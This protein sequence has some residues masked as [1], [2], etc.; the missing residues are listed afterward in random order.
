M[1]Y[2]SVHR[3]LNVG[4]TA[5]QARLA[6]KSVHR[7]SGDW[8]FKGL[9]GADGGALKVVELDDARHGRRDIRSPARRCDLPQGLT[10][11]D[12]GGHGGGRPHRRLS[13]RGRGGRGGQ[14]GKTAECES[15]AG[16][17]D[18]RDNS[19]GATAAKETR[20]RLGTDRPPLPILL[21]P[22]R[23]GRVLPDSLPATVALSPVAPPGGPH[24]R[25]LRSEP[26]Q[27]LPATAQGHRCGGTPHRQL[28]RVGGG[29]RHGAT[30]R[31]IS[32]TMR[33]GHGNEVVG[34]QQEP[35]SGGPRNG[36]PTE[37]S[38]DAPT[39]PNPRRRAGRGRDG[40]G[41]HNYLLNACSTNACSIH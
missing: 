25:V 20:L 2:L 15:A 16:E 31:V 23:S 6:V 19:E 1:D 34:H 9:P 14:T 39:S 30:G 10:R 13:G 4:R 11:T 26:L 28:R 12:H 7:S 40:D 27:L 24:R 18:H 37:M 35:R 21:V 17:R 32:R 3:R 38:G 33:R 5:P 8:D 22:R 29:R 36:S 41:A